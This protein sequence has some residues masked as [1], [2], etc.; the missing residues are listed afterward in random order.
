VGMA[1]IAQACFDAAALQTRDLIEAMRADAPE[2]FRGGVELR[3]DGG[4]SKSAWFGQRLADLAGVGVARALYRETTAL[5][6][7]LFAGLGCGL[8]PDVET[9]AKSRPATEDYA[10]RLDHHAREAVYARWLDAVTRVR[11]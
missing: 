1:E 3:I 6:A 7:A 5:G 11:S 9:A 10:P 4:M 2:S 8:Y